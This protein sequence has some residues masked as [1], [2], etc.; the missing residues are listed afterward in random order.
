MCW[1]VD[2]FCF[3]FIKD[4]YAV[5]DGGV[6]S[7]NLQTVFK[8]LA[9][10][11]LC[12]AVWNNINDCDETFNYW[13]PVTHFNLLNNLNLICLVFKLHYLVYGS[14]FQTWEYSPEYALRSYAYILLHALPTKLYGIILQSNRILVFYFLRCLLG[15]IC[16][17]LETY[18]YR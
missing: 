14:G 11:R 2:M 10:A 9:S 6:W 13:E 3:R 7:P 15:F 12:A 4:N 8:A 5:K 1:L 17:S 18:F 16:T